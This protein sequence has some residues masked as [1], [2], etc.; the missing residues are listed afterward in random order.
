MLLPM[1]SHAVLVVADAD[2]SNAATLFTT[3]GCAVKVAADAAD[4]LTIAATTPLS[5]VVLPRHP[6][7]MCFHELATAISQATLM[8]SAV[9]PAIAQ[10][11]A[12]WL[13][14]TSNQA[15]SSAD[16]MAASHA[17]PAAPA[18]S[19]AA[20]QPEPPTVDDSPP[21][22]FSVLAT[23]E[24]DIGDAEFVNATIDI[25]LDEMPGRLEGIAAGIAAGAATAFGPAAHSLKS[26]SAM[27]GALRLSDTCAKI[28]AL[29]G[30]HDVAGAAVLLPILEAEAAAA[31]TVLRQLLA[32]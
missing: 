11:D 26:S 18:P 9:A 8:V 29:A 32:G 27:L 6:E 13:T 17:Q 7:G 2:G 25:Y 22:D 12:D 15:T 31:A 20:T 3:A 4:A 14:P 24:S 16:S 1:S 19:A 23:L 30:S 5:L 28:E 10:V 21:I